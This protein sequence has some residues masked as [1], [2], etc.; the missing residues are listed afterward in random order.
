MI[1]L[2]L[3]GKRTRME[4]VLT[5]CAIGW[6]IAATCMAAVQNFGGAFACRLLTGLGGT[7]TLHVIYGISVKF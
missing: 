3:L 2:A 7:Y 6:G 5:I 1:P 4:K